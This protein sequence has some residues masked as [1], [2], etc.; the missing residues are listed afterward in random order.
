MQVSAHLSDGTQLIGDEYISVTQLPVDKVSQ[1][2]V[3]REGYPPVTLAVDLDAGERIHFFTR[4]S[5]QLGAEPGGTLSVPVYEIRKN[6]ALVAR[7]YWPPGSGPI[8][9]TQDLYF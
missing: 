4:N 8:L 2:T 9:S 5:I 1:V 3:T 7:L 6:D